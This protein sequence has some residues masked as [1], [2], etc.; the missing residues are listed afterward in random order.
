MSGMGPHS[1]R[2][3][4]GCHRAMPPPPPKKCLKLLTA[5]QQLE[6][7][8]WGPVRDRPPPRPRAANP[9]YR[10]FSVPQHL[11]PK[12]AGGLA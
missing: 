11:S 7:G 4:W 12:G 2:R 9:L 8:W 6:G 5:L 3:T 10:A 1:R